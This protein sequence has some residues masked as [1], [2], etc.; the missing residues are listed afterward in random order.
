MHFDALC[1]LFLLAC[2]KRTKASKTR[3]F[4]KKNKPALR[5]P[6][7][8]STHVRF[9]PAG[10][11]CSSQTTKNHGRSKPTNRPRGGRSRRAMLWS[12]VLC[13]G[14]MELAYGATSMDKTVQHKLTKVRIGWG[15][16][17]QKRKGNPWGSFFRRQLWIAWCCCFSCFF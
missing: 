14:I 4:P 16:K 17:V 9:V 13:S 6:T 11:F 2:L 3:S 1:F 15:W 7:F 5:F 12:L 8:K 10:F